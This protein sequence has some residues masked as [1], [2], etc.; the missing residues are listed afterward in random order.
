MM[1]ARRRGGAGC[2]RLRARLI[3]VCA[4][5]PPIGVVAFFVLTASA[6][7][8]PTLRVSIG[9]SGL[10][11]VTS[12][13]AG[14]DCPATCVATFPENSEVVLTAVPAPGYQLGSRNLNGW[15]GCG[16]VSPPRD[17]CRVTIPAARAAS[18][19]AHFYPAAYLQVLAGGRGSVTATI[20]EA[21][22]GEAAT[23]TCLGRDGD[24]RGY[25]HLMYLPRRSV[26]LT[27]IPDA[28][29]GTTFGAWSDERCPSRPVC[30]LVLD[31]E[32]QSVTALF[33]PQRLS[34]GVD[35][36]QAGTVTSS[37]PGIR[38]GPSNGGGARECEAHFPLF[39]EVKLT[40][41]G[42]PPVRWH[43]C[44][45]VVGSTC[46][47]IMN[48]GRVPDVGFGG[49]PPGVSG[50]FDVFVIF[51]AR[52]AGAGSGTIRSTA[53]GLYCG[54]RCTI[55]GT[56]GEMISLIADPDP[57]SHFVRWRG[58]CSSQPTCRL[59]IGPVTRVAGVFQRNRVSSAPQRPALRPS[60]AKRRSDRP[61][62]S[63]RSFVAHLSYLVV[64]GRGRGRAV[65]FR[66]RANAAAE[67]RATLIRNRRSVATRR[68]RMAPGSRLLRWRLPA[69]IRSGRY[70]ISI[71]VRRGSG[72]SKRFSRSIRLPR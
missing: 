51:H 70:R 66:L 11:A 40:A 56:F 9:E 71:A 57:G 65:V 47:L 3:R 38:C 27:A 46:H 30:T 39:S 72:P 42:P 45:S 23:G 67:V 14:I 52:P 5:V 33:S 16:V 35:P 41:A 25:C 20:A 50:V 12:Q 54:R 15:E 53:S 1:S 7:G 22:V 44:D 63:T 60:P 31:D 28:A 4:V 58:A 21:R 6:L 2:S 26:T 68:W 48:R 55:D 19:T 62:V 18:V 8:A 61:S 10:G 64:R 49:L 13:P 32:R 17:V 37:P 36:A 59:A 34:V 29:T 43:R 69:R 24:M